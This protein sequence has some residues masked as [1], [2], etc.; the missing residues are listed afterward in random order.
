MQRK[1]K[2]S[3]L[4]KVPHKVRGQRLTQMSWLP[5]QCS[6]AFTGVALEWHRQR[7][8]FL[9]PSLSRRYLVIG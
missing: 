4:L 3:N 7:Q 8:K 9:E 6:H 1:L 5:V 2:M